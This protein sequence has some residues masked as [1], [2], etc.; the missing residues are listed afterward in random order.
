MVTKNINRLNTAINKVYYVR[1]QNPT[2]WHLQEVYIKCKN[3]EKLRSSNRKTY[4][5][6]TLIKTKI[7]KYISTKLTLSQEA[8]SITKRV[9][10]L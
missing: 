4:I 2:I 7:Y 8:I 9:N 10:I 1:N 3:L 5:V 6:Q